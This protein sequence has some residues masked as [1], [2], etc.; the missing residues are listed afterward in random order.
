MWMHC[1]R[2]ALLQDACAVGTHVLRERM[3]CMMHV[4]RGCI[5]ALCIAAGTHALRDACAV[6]RM[7]C[8]FVVLKPFTLGSTWELL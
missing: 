4:L 8:A 6:G 1:C 2:D 5:A 7:L 3:C